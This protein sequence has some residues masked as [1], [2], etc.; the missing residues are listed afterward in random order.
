MLA[1]FISLIGSTPFPGR[2]K[3]VELRRGK[4]S[5]FVTSTS[6][7]HIFVRR[8]SSPSYLLVPV[9]LTAWKDRPTRRL[10]SSE[11]CVSSR[12]R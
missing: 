6:R 8:T 11:R 3:A 9:V 5:S 12:R 10:C 4:E 7:A 2:R 1:R